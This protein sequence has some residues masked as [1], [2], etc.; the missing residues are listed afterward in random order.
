[1]NRW[2]GRLFLIL[3]LADAAAHDLT[4][5]VRGPRCRVTGERVHPA[6]RAGHETTNHRWEGPCL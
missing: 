6:K 4:N 2:R 5:L 3:A 1:V